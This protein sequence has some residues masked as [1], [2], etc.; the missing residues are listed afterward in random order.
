M[1]ES[2]IRC[3]VAYLDACDDTDAA[4]RAVSLN[5]A[6]AEAGVRAVVC[7]GIFPGVSNLMAAS[8]VRAGRE[9]GRGTPVRLSFSYFTGALVAPAP[10][11]RAFGRI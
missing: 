6:A 8:M 1:L 11:P 2:A 10:S 7:G 4:A 3:G 5:A 9:D